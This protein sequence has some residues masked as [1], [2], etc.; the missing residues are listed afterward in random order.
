MLDVKGFVQ[1]ES[2]L[3]EWN[4]VRS[5]DEPDSYNGVFSPYVM[6]LR[7]PLLCII[8]LG[9]TQGTLYSGQ[10]GS[11]AAGAQRKGD[12]CTSGIFGGTAGNMNRP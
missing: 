3:N 10:S 5:W 8:L 6:D 12:C 4:Y 2:V 7:P 1:T 11:P 9:K